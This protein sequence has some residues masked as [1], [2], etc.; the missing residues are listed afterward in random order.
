MPSTGA[1]GGDTPNYRG[2]CKI[3]AAE[4]VPL[5]QH[6][7]YIPCWGLSD[8]QGDAPLCACS[9]GSDTP[10][11]E[12]FSKENSAKTMQDRR[13]SCLKGLYPQ[14][15][16]HWRSTSTSWGAQSSPTPSNPAGIRRR[17]SST[18]RDSPSLML[19]FQGWWLSTSRCWRAPR[20]YQQWWGWVEPWW[21][22]QSPDAAPLPSRGCW[23]LPFSRT[24]W[25][26]AW[27]HGS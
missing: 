7:S 16:L 25:Y 4:W 17:A 8:A 26:S 20:R 3:L 12:G 18:W 2:S 9:M 5:L 6:S 13:F 22:Q 23:R 10:F 24:L 14:I 27:L 11:W 15:A 1:W 19:A 21:R